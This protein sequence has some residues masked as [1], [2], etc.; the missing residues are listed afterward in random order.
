MTNY[1]ENGVVINKPDGTQEVYPIPYNFGNKLITEEDILE[2]LH[3][4]NISIDKIRDISIFYDA[5][6]HKSYVLDSTKSKIYTPDILEASKKELGDIKGLMELRDTS[7]ER[8]EYLGDRVL[9]LIVSNYLFERYP[10]ESEGFMTRLQTKIEDKTNLA[11]LSKIIG[12]GKFFIISKQIELN[13]GRQLD[14]IHEDVFEAFI[15]AL[16]LSENF[17]VCKSL[18]V[19]LIETEMDLS[20]KLYCDNNYK[21]QLLRYHH[22]NSYLNPTFGM[23]ASEG[24]PHERKYIIGLLKQEY[25]GKKYD[26]LNENIYLSFGKGYSKKEGEQKSAKM[27]LILYNQL[28]EDQYIMTDIY[29]PD[30]EKI[31]LLV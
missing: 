21:D 19:N 17:D 2:I 13:N 24:K 9:K 10:T 3:V 29:Y 14:K 18:I 16:Y 6:T 27:A 4:N 31:K 5:F 22:K 15:A 30:F 28:N 11:A 8:Y 7:Y 1:I 23:I 25:I 20:E 12:L 26:K